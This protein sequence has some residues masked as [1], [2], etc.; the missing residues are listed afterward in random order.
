MQTL[1]I[2]CSSPG[3]VGLTQIN[4]QESARAGRTGSATSS[5]AS[6]V[7]RTVTRTGC[8]RRSQVSITLPWLERALVAL[9][10]GNRKA[11]MQSLREMHAACCDLVR[12]SPCIRKP[13]SSLPKHRRSSI[14]PDCSHEH[15][16]ATRRHATRRRGS[17]KKSGG[18]DFCPRS[19]PDIA[20]A[21]VLFHF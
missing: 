10:Q 11:A 12:V 16:I 15:D 3:R 6:L 13:R 7:T 17:P 21:A 4:L 19:P 18:A 8:L 5:Y 14:D 2:L 20:M 1:W 9:A